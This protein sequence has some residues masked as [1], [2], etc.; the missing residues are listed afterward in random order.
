MTGCDMEKS[1]RPARIVAFLAVLVLAG[2]SGMP[3]AGAQTCDPASGSGCVT[4][5]EGHVGFAVEI[6]I[7]G[8]KQFF[9]ADEIPSSNGVPVGADAA[10]TQ[11]ASGVVT[12]SG[13]SCVGDMSGCMNLAILASTRAGPLPA[14]TTVNF[15]ILQV[16]GLPKALV[17]AACRLVSRSPGGSTLPGSGFD[18]TPDSVGDHPFTLLADEPD[19]INILCEVTSAQF[20]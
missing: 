12:L 16:S 9:S 8:V 3:G 19:G 17:V 5:P 15:R 4:F 2:V 11:D 7:D 18:I 1:G 10:V 14:G 20:D 6:F 13:R